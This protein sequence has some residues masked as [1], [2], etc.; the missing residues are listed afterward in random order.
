MAEPYALETAGDWAGAAAAFERR[1]LPYDAA[2]ARLGGD[3]C[4][5]RAALETFTRLGAHVPA[6]LARLRLRRLGERRGTRGP[7]N[8][9]RQ[10]SYGLTSRQMDVLT[11]IAEGWSNAEIAERLVLSQNTIGH[12]VSTILNKLGVRSRAEAAG[13]LR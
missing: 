6:E 5:V 2:L 13:K 8:T 7:R 11:L 1:G 9:S 4:A 12:H 10:N 3:A